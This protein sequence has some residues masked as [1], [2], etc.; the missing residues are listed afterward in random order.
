MYEFESWTHNEDWEL[1][2]WYFWIVVLENSWELNCKIKSVNHKENQPWI[3]IE[4]TDAKVEAPILWPPDVK[5][6][7]T[8]KD[9]DAG[10]RW[11]QRRRM[12]QIMTW[13]DSIMVSTD[14]NLSKLQEIVKDREAWCTAVHGNCKECNICKDLLTEQLQILLT[15]EFKKSHKAW[16]LIYSIWQQMTQ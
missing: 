3:C 12:W 8:G 1:K 7:L 13:L 15:R 2:N 4:R 14:I 16:C 10:K 9:P 11:R 5:S 6:W